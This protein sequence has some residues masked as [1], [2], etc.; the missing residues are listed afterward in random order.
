MLTFW[1]DVYEVRHNSDC[2]RAFFF[3]VGCVDLWEPKV[4]RAAMGAHFRLPIL[5]SLAWNDIETHL[6]KS[7]TV[8]VADS[9]CGSEISSDANHLRVDVPHKPAKAGNYGWIS[10]HREDVIYD[11]DSDSDCEGL[12]LPVV[13]SR[14][15]HE[16]WASGPTALVVGGETHGLSVESVQLAEKTAGNRLFIPVVPH[17][18]SLNSAMAASILLF[19]GRKQLLK[20]QQ[21]TGRSRAEQRRS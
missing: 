15:Y 11:S 18:D 12:Q 17:M 6:P 10:S 3:S 20:L 1:G 19:E 5:Q 16:G 9:S 14:V 4:L 2:L 7:V 8:H 13:D 21:T